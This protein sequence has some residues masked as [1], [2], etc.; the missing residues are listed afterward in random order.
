MVKAISS[1]FKCVNAES[2]V[3][4]VAAEFEPIK[5]HSRT[6]TVGAKSCC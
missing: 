1:F 5:T 6:V 3:A 2:Q 4:T